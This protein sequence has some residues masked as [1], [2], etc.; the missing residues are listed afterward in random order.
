MAVISSG[1]KTESD[2][3]F[4]IERGAMTSLIFS[5]IT[6]AVFDEN[7]EKADPDDVTG[8][9]SGWALKTGSGKRQAFTETINLATDSWSWEGELSAVQKFTFSVNGL[10]AGYFIEVTVFSDNL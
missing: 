1:L 7:Q 4:D 6:V 2:A 8:V 9:L 5:E 3:E 10:N